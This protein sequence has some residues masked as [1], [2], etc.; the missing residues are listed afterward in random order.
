MMKIRDSS[1]WSKPEIAGFLGDSVIPVRLACVTP[2]GAPLV[3]SLWYVYA[4]DAIWCATQQSAAVVKYLEKDSRCAFEIAPEQPPYKGVRGQGRASLVQAEGQ[5]VLLRLVDRY[6]GD[7]ES[8][9]ARWLIKRSD[10]EMAIRISP[11][12]I[13]SWDFAARMNH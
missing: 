4:D 11:D 8:G 3:C 9:F 12:W 5:D 7:R 10:T 13:T 1:A 6:L 2:S